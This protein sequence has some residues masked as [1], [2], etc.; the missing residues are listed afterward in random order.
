MAIRTP[1]RA[2]NLLAGA[3]GQAALERVDKLLSE[4]RTRSARRQEEDCIQ[5]GMIWRASQIPSNFVRILPYDFA[6]CSG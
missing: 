6:S 1:E 5:W 3:R 2:D 4:T